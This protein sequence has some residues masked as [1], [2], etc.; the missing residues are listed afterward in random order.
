MADHKLIAEI[1]YATPSTP[2]AVPRLLDNLE[3]HSYWALFAIIGA[4]FSGSAFLVYT[5]P[6]RMI[7]TFLVGYPVCVIALFG[8]W[9]RW[10]FRYWV[11]AGWLLMVLP[12]PA[13]RAISQTI[14]AILFELSPYLQF[15]SSVTAPNWLWIGFYWIVFTPLSVLLGWLL[16]GRPWREDTKKA[17][18]PVGIASIIGMVVIVFV[19]PF[20]GI[21]LHYIGE[22]LSDMGH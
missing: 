22:A 9:T 16:I 7:D 15:T 13:W 19:I 14:G 18:P 12:I 4:L 6:S 2:F 1:P 3:H 21:W 17:F 20:V 8:G 10:R 5:R 11:A